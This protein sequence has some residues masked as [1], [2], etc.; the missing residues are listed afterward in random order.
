MQSAN[1]WAGQTEAGFETGRRRKR[2]EEE[3]LPCQERWKR[4][5]SIL[6]RVE[7]RRHTSH[8][9]EPEEHGPE[10]C[11]MGTEQPQ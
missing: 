1:G 11:P 7:D 8:V 9:K 5:D 4:G 2:K 6:R 10:G 3:D